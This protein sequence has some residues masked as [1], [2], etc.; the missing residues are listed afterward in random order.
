MNT[1]TAD[2]PLEV[3][4]RFHSGHLDIDSANTGTATATVQALDP[5]DQHS[6]EIARSARVELDGTRLTVDVPGKWRRSSHVRVRLCL[7]ELS[8]VTSQSGD[9]VVTSTGELGELRV[10]TG[11]GEVRAPAVRGAV[12]IKAGAATVVVGTAGSI[13]LAS[14]R[15]HLTAQSV[16]DV[17]FK[18]GHGEAALQS[19]SGQVIVKGGGVGLEV[20]EAG[21][22]EVHFDVGSGSAHVGVLEGTTVQLDLSSGRGDVRCDLPLDSAAPEGG[23]GLRVRLRT[24]SGDVVVGRAQP[25]SYDEV[26]G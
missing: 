18:A 20:R 21:S 14:G 24:G 22:G 15:A 17:A 26:S 1:Y 5:A 8:S 6:V 4:V 11:S 7:P 9:V 13:F 19:T 3:R 25:S 23:A 2:A 16:G 12:D 10:R